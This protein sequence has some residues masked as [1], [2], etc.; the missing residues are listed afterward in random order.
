MPLAGDAATALKIAR[1]AKRF[2]EVAAATVAG[3][4][5][6]FVASEGKKVL[7]GQAR[8]DPTFSTKPN[9]PAHLQG[10]LLEEVAEELR[11]GT[12]HP[13]QIPIEAFEHPSGHLVTV[14]NRGL[15]AL[16]MAGMKPTKI[17]IRNATKKER[18][19]LRETSVLG[20]ALPAE[21]IGITLN[22]G[23]KKVLQI[24]HLPR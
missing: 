16:S 14:N 8:V 11:A 1:N 6:G 19:R 3:E 12:M 21:R 24:I 20:D 2:G 22:R 5:V 15:T 9:V 13:D 18:A 4:K 10:R 17:S 7:F 23:S